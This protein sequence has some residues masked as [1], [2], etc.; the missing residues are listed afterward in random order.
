MFAG[1]K[2][3]PS[4]DRLDRRDITGM[5]HCQAR[6]EHQGRLVSVGSKYPSD[7]HEIV[8]TQRVGQLDTKLH[9][10]FELFEAK[11]R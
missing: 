11:N 6:E 2:P 7:L 1:K 4:D 5:A 8:F 10:T 3:R 9:P